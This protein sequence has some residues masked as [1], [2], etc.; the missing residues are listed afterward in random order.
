MN[1]EEFH[2]RG[3]EAART[4][5]FD[6]AVEAFGEVARLRP[7]SAPAHYNLARALGDAGRRDEAIEACRRALALDPNHFEAAGNLGGLLLAAGRIDEAIAIFQRAIDLRPDDAR[8]WYNFATALRDAG[9]LDAAIAAYRRAVERKPDFFPAVQNLAIALQDIGRMTEAADAMR[10]AIALRPQDARAWFN[11]G[12]TLERMIRLDDAADVYRQAIRFDPA[13]AE[14]RANLAGVLRD[15]G[16]IRESIALYRQSLELRPHPTAADSLLCT[17]QYDPDCKPAE[18]LEEYR[19]WDERFGRPLA[20]VS[21]A[22]RAARSADARLRIGLVSPDFHEHPVGWCLLPVL[23]HHDRAMM[24]MICFSD[25]R[26]SDATTARLR[27]AADA[28]HE[29]AALSDESLADRIAAERIDILLDLAAHTRGNRL[30]VFARRPAPVQAS[31]LGWP[32]T[33]GLSAIDFRLS[34]PYL[35]PPSDEP[36]GVER[37]VRLESFWCCDPRDCPFEPGPPPVERSGFITF[38]SLN[39]FAKM[40][41][42]TA[43]LWSRI[44][45]EAADSRL[46]LRAPESNARDAVRRWFADAGVNPSRLEFV[47]RLPREQY[48]NLYRR[49]DVTLDPI[50]HGGHTTAMDSLWMGV[51][52]VTLIGTIPAWR[53]GW[54]V[55]SNVGTPELAA[56]DT[57]SYVRTAV[58]LARDSART[59]ALRGTLREKMR[60][61]ALMDAPRFTRRLMTALQ[62]ML[63]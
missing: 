33:T 30:R 48:W 12:V 2:A 3:I 41:E 11:L 58:A 62:S 21:R 45:G 17:M 47:D 60:T 28:W 49:I 1:A 20:P 16:E 9:R 32:G 15:T 63:A 7:D 61:S 22:I 43:E 52:V 34:D 53:A 51:P 23:A 26:R 19:R 39:N 55:L 57:E 29:T 5:R 18:L 13:F 46:L 56:P 27:A 59:A 8:A 4:G 38:G 35:D 24:E 42:R 54:S 50:P 36:F 37:I 44:L 40:N 6:Q 14:A 25:V 31:W 10:R